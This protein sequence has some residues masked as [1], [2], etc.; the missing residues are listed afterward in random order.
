MPYV[1]EGWTAVSTS[2]EC[3]PQSNI[4]TECQ[5]YCLLP[6]WS[7]AWEHLTHMPLP[8]PSSFSMRQKPPLTSD[9]PNTFPLFLFYMS[10]SATWWL[11][12]LHCRGSWEWQS[13]YRELKSDMKFQES[14]FNVRT[15]NQLWA[16]CTSSHFPISC[17]TDDSEALPQK[18]MSFKAKE[19]N[20]KKLLFLPFLQLVCT[21]ETDKQDKS[22]MQL[23]AFLF[24]APRR[25]TV[26]ER[27]S[28]G[29]VVLR[30]GTSSVHAVGEPAENQL[31]WENTWS[32]PPEGTGNL[33]EVLGLI[34]LLSSLLSKSKM[35][36]CNSRLL[37]QI[38]T[39]Y[40]KKAKD[41]KGKGLLKAPLKMPLY[42]YYMIK[43]ELPTKLQPVVNN[44]AMKVSTLFTLLPLFF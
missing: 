15:T 37:R 27:S 42:S 36:N 44:A 14:S 2:A 34:L 7:S 35:K 19:R 24:I 38:I 5:H 40:S 11:W 31:S 25:I 43:L 4:I 16:T 8:T 23:G 20:K 29:A 22:I 13:I 26:W 17:T 3:W 39:V 33:C 30:W 9:I 28:R 21:S 18:S 10:P 41:D 1:W 32:Q 12:L 6:W